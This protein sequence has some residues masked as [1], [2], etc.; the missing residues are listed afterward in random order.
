MHHSPMRNEKSISLKAGTFALGVAVSLVV[1]L[2]ACSRHQSPSAA[3]SEAFNQHGARRDDSEKVLNLASWGDYIAPDTVPNFERE[4]GIKVNYEIY[5]NN[6][7]LEA[8]LM[9]GHTHYDVVVPTSGFFE[10]QRQA[11]IYRKLDKNELP[12]LGNTDPATMQ[13]LA[14]EDPGNL[15]AVPYMYSITGLAYNVDQVRKRVGTQAP[16]SWALL[17]EAGSAAKLKDCGIAIVDSPTDVFMAAIMY[18]GHDPNR[19]DPADLVAASAL[20]QKI[21]P[22]VRYVDPAQHV[23]DLANGTVC[24]ALAW[25]GDAGQARRRALESKTGAD[26][27]FFIPREGGLII[28]DMMA[29]PADAPHVRNASLWLNYLLRPDVIANITN[30][31]KYPNGN[32]AS[33]PLVAADIKN[34][35]TVYPDARTRERLISPHSKPMEYSRQMTREWTRFRTGY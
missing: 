1:V 14:V 34:D 28:V 4:T 21:R 12:N 15:Y 7:V 17:F 25:A 10:K 16:D 8:K 33:L 18:L 13:L 30:F 3:A 27:S 29:I 24:L 35:V 5:D 23:P 20:L 32:A 22:F 6:E 2:D 19:F 11:G 31:I 26:V 9:T